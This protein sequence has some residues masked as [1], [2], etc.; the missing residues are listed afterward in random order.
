MNHKEALK[1][2][3][4]IKATFK[5]LDRLEQDLVAAAALAAQKAE[6][7]EGVATLEIQQRDLENAL[8]TMEQRREK[9][10]REVAAEIADLDE[11]LAHQRSR[12]E[13]ELASSKRDHDS[14]M[15]VMKNERIVQ[16]VRSGQ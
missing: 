9:R 2:V 5:D 15:R 3:G 10:R 16:A 1:F 4:G 8:T 6:L 13:S 11:A 12:I 14:R 7:E